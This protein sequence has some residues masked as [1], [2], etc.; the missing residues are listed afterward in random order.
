MSDY[1]WVLPE[2]V[3]VAKDEGIKLKPMPPVPS[4]YAPQILHS[5]PKGTYLDLHEHAASL[6][7]VDDYR[8]SFNY[9]GLLSGY[10]LVKNIFMEVCN[11]DGSVDLEA[12]AEHRFVG[13]R[14]E[15]VQ[16]D[17]GPPEA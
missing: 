10:V 13:L 3:R 8:P 12:T 7:A 6:Y 9:A 17:A 16:E 11:D 1:F 5:T 4:G 14:Y 15:R 2:A